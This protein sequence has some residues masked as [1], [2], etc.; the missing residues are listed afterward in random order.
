[1]TLGTTGHCRQGQVRDDVKEEE[2]RMAH[3]SQEK[4]VNKS[5]I[6]SIGEV[7]HFDSLKPWQ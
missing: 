7:I 5:E 2:G 3:Q 4:M 1:M 6:T